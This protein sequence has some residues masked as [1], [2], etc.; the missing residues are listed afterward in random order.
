MYVW[1]YVCV[2]S[3]I[4]KRPALPPCKVDGRFRNPLYD[5][6]DHHRYYQKLMFYRYMQGCFCLSVC[7][8]VCLSPPS[9]SK[10]CTADVTRQ[11]T[12]KRSQS[13]L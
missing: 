2:V 6:D 9:L 7:L 8:F 4:V 1:M 13:T 3:F 5:D 10:V 11:I 12:Q